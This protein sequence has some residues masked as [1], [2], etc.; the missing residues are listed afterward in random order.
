M[1]V[2]RQCFSKQRRMLATTLRSSSD[3]GEVT[4][5]PLFGS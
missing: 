2:E 1:K 5:T 3:K 4:R